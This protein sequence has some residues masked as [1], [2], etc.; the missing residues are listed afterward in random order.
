MKFA[1]LSDLHIGSWRDERLRDVSMAVFLKAV[2]MC[3]E[4][5][6]DFILFAGDL[7]NTA[8]PAVDKLAIVARVLREL[9]EEG[10]PVYVIPGSHDFSPSG[11]TMIDVLEHGGLLV[12]VYKGDVVSKRLRLRFTI[13]RKTGAKITGILGKKGML[14][15]TFY[16]DLDREAIE[17]EKG[18]KIF[19]FHTALQELRPTHLEHMEAQPVSLLP[20]GFDYYAG[21]HVHHRMEFSAE[22]YKKVTQPGALFPNNF[23]ELEKYGHGGFFIVQD[24]AVDW[25]P[26]KVRERIALTLDADGKR[27]EDVSAELMELINNVIPDALVTVRVHG[28]LSSGQVSDI[29]FNDALAEA[30]ARGA[31]AVLKNTA[32]L[33]SKELEDVE[34]HAD[35]IEQI[36]EQLIQEHAK[37]GAFGEKTVTL[38]KELMQ[39]LSAEKKEGETVRDFEE[40]VKHGGMTAL[41]YN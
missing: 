5:K 31:H 35:S 23:A 36:E 30:Y 9:K 26:I 21:G 12:N 2:E 14:D 41:K 17:R 25:K 20:R 40:R 4:E 32:A 6:V 29:S 16:E 37:N 39:A 34:I 38:V 24:D 33:A 19:M 7:F 15:R 8:F 11:T 22:G 27:A 28:I 1:H 13:D 18:Y 3:K 10:I